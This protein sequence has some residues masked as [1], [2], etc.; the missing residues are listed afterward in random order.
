MLEQRRSFWAAFE[1]AADEA[2]FP[3]RWN[4]R[5]SI[6]HREGP[7]AWA[8]RVRDADGEAEVLIEHGTR[9]ENDALFRALRGN[10]SAVARSFGEALLWEEVPGGRRFRIAAP[11]RVG[12]VRDLGDWA[13]VQNALLADLHRLDTALRPYLRLAGID[14]TWC[15]ALS[16]AS[17]SDWH[18]EPGDLIKRTEL[19]TRYGGS[20]QGGIA[21]SATTP[22][23]LIFSDPRT[24]S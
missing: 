7:L 22:N 20:G 19:H 15:R 9:D 12:G 23:V 2:G 18:L 11:T 8:A 16:D 4:N 1:R 17:G 10:R 5:T 3:G 14:D 24:G 13:A 6:R 21:G